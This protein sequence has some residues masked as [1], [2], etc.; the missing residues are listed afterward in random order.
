LAD[1]LAALN[2]DLDFIL[3][4][5]IPVEYMPEEKA[6]R[7]HAIARRTYMI[8]GIEYPL[9]EPDEVENLCVQRGNLTGKEMEIMREH[10]VVTNKLLAQIPFTHKLQH[11]PVIAGAHH[12][13][14]N[15]KGYPE[16]LTAEQIPYQARMLTIA[17][18]YDA[19]TASDRSYKKARSPEEA[20]RILGFMAKDGE[21]DS[22]LLQLFQEMIFGENNNSAD[23]DAAVT[24]RG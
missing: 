2:S 4:C 15:G 20:L 6:L 9:L 22:E 13:K 12:E 17:D 1:K 8:Q 11:V 24:E 3:E 7:I 21:I 5:N 18:V 19:L 14:L 10:A 23:C 16:G